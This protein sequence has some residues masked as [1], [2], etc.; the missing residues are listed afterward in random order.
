MK[1]YKWNINEKM[2]RKICSLQGWAGNPEP[3]PKT[4]SLESCWWLVLPSKLPST[5]QYRASQYH[6]GMT[7]GPL[8]TPCSLSKGMLLCSSP[9][10]LSASQPLHSPQAVP[11]VK[12]HLQTQQAPKAFIF[13]HVLWKHFALVNKTI[14]QVTR[15]PGPT[16]ILLSVSFSSPVSLL[17]SISSDPLEPLYVPMCTHTRC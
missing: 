4:Q 8:T 7:N 10:L 6:D 1:V 16:A 9:D 2:T 17:M 3:S 11:V 14:W 5:A 12:P 13:A 15:F